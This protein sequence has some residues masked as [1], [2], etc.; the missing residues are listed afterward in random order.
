MSFDPSKFMTQEF[1]QANDTKFVN[2]PA[3]EWTGVTGEPK[4]VDGVSNKDGRTFY[5]LE[6]PVMI[7]DP[8][9]TSETGRTPTN[10]RYETFLD[11][12]DGGS[13]DMGKGKNIGLGKIREATGNNKPGVNFSIPNLGG[14]MVKVLVAHEA[15]KNKPDVVYERVKAVTAA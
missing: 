13:I 9:V 5:K 11:M 15:D 4:I 3:G 8:R 6:I 2:C 14:K 10:V 12:T 7:E 1:N